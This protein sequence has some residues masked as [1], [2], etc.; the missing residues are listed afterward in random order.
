MSVSDFSGILFVNM[1]L[2]FILYVIF[3][4]TTVRRLKKQ[5]EAK[6][7]LGEVIVASEG[8]NIMAS[9]SY[10]EFFV[11]AIE[12]GQE[13]KGIRVIADKKTILENTN[14]FE[15]CF[16]RFIFWLFNISTMTLLAIAIADYF[17]G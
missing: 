10:P 8:Y 1:I 5:D 13:K 15:R 7:K 6:E 3:G 14:M 4:F 12:R 17:R 9:L 11:K 2:S 16:A